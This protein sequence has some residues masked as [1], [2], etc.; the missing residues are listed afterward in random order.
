[1][2]ATPSAVPSAFKFVLIG[3]L[4]ADRRSE[5]ADWNQVHITHWEALGNLLRG[6]P[7]TAAFGKFVSSFTFDSR[8]V[9]AMSPKTIL[10]I[11]IHV[12]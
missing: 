3:V 2:V 9:E 5:R 12:V 4:P 11:C 6:V 10:R 8:A 1:M 7:Q